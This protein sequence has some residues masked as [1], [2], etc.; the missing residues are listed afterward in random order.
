MLGDLDPAGFLAE[1]WQKR[2]LLVRGA[3][4]GFSAPISPEEL[5]GLAC[6]D[7]VDCRI[8]LESAGV[9]P[10]ELRPGPFD[11]ATFAGLPERG[12][13]LLVQE[14]DRHDPEVARLWEGLRFLPNWRTDDVMVSYAAPGGGVGAHVDNYDVFLLQGQGRKR[15]RVE[16]RPRGDDEETLI[17]GADLRVLDRFR[18]EREW[19]LEPGDLLY[20]PP[21][22][23]HE[24]VA[25]DACTTFSLGFRAPS[26]RELV[27][28]LLS[29]LLEEQGHDPRYADP[30][31]IPADDP[32]RIDPAAV[33]WALE[34]L[35]SVTAD[36][37]RIESWFGCFIS[38]PRRATRE[39]AGPLDADGLRRAL[40][41]GSRLRR[42]AP[43]LLAWL[44]R[45][46]GG[47]SLF[48]AG[49]EHRLAAGLEYAAPLICGVGRLDRDTLGGNAGLWK[50]LE[51]LVA[52]GALELV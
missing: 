8:V 13:T 50:L 28:G 16:G 35:A 22:H 49:R 41:S 42:V 25:L 1:Y 11:E 27:G 14:V 34:Q 24:G 52:D 47:V 30:K 26:R 23:A 33:A 19:V 32:G 6:V 40:G 18:P 43:S 12:W 38:E 37:G 5:A 17:E 31:R 39:T 45:A 9:R 2:P 3:M 44:R 21:R 29:R 10:W 20:L 7:E 36:R 48:G 4:A 15:W 46:D 51:T